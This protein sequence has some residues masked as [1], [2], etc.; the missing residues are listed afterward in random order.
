MRLS[1]CPQCG[2]RYVRILYGLPSPSAMER[3][4]K[5]EIV[6][7]GCLMEKDSPIGKCSKCNTFLN[8]D[9][10]TEEVPGFDVQDYLRSIQ[11]TKKQPIDTGL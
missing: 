9:F 4:K 7:G 8:R 2:G 11:E 5:G 3:A 6:L 1:R 10:T